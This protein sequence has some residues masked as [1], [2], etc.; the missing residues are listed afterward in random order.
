M[1]SFKFPLGTVLSC[2]V[3]D[4]IPLTVIGHR[5]NS[6]GVAV[7]DLL[8]EGAKFGTCWEASW[9]ER[10][11]ERY[12]VYPK[13]GSVWVLKGGHALRSEWVEVIGLAPHKNRK[14]EWLLMFQYL[15]GYMG[16]YSEPLD[17]FLEAWE[18]VDK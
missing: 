13:P 5:L 18:K 6:D 2:G 1:H 7:Y 15:D 4:K 16:V 10:T 3:G 14:G 8:P 11:H 9:V 12:V 17:T